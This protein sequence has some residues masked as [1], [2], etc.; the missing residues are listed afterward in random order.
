MTHAPITHVDLFPDFAAM[1]T[2]SLE[3]LC[4]QAFNQLEE[5]PL[6]EGLFGFYLS[7]SAELEERSMRPA[8]ITP[9]AAPAEAAGS[10][11][12]PESLPA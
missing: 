10:Y 12:A 3:A 4:D 7:L 11:P 1:N 2:S 9:G 6:I 8:D 5:G